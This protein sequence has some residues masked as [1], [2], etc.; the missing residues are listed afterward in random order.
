MPL[1]TSGSRSTSRAPRSSA[2]RKLRT[3]ARGSAAPFSVP[4]ALLI[5][6]TAPL[7]AAPGRSGTPARS[8]KAPDVAVTW[9]EKKLQLA[10]LPADLPAPARAVIETWAPWAAEN[11]YRLDLDAQGRILLV[12]SERS[13]GPAARLRAIAKTETW[14]DELFPAPKAAPAEAPKAPAAPAGIPEDPEAPPP[15]APA[16][17]GTT[18]KPAS[19]SWTTSWGAGAGGMDRTTAVFFVIRDER[20]QAALLDHLAAEHAYLAAWTATAKKQTGFVLEEPLCGG[21]VEKARGQQEWDPEHELVNRVGQLLLLRR[22]GQEPFWLQQAVGWEAE[23]AFD[24]SLFCFPYRDEFVFAT[25]HTGWPV[26]LKNA[27]K[28]RADTPLTMAELAAWQRGR[29]DSARAHAAW[30]LLHHLVSTKP[31]ELTPTLVELAR[32]RTEHDKRSTGPNSWEK[33]PGYEIPAPDQERIFGA[34]FGADVLE[35]ASKAFRKGLDVSK[36]A[37]KSG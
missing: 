26:E 7:E 24:G 27:F 20:D 28:D 37:A 18:P 21:Y 36:A 2:A 9:K 34:R 5:A 8:E 22:F 3:L 1:E 30:G 23:L 33:I 13:T 4:L 16:T 29:Y 14:F 31:A 35:Q 11:D 32:F 12:S 25:E 17:G 19:T 6:L 10:K 15:G